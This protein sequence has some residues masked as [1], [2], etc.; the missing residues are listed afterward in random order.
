MK[1]KNVIG[2]DV[3]KL[4][5]DAIIHS[6]QHSFVFANT[7]DGFKSLLKTVFKGGK[8]ETDEHAA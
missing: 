4:S 6:N 1:F 7:K 5:N 8:C 3:G 2:I